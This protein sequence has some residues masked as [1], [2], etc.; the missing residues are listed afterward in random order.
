MINTRKQF[1]EKQKTI[2]VSHFIERS[3]YREEMLMTNEV[4]Y[5][6]IERAAAQ[7]KRGDA[8]FYKAK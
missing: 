6:I 8:T 7:K 4:S 1:I 3:L 5:H 2:V